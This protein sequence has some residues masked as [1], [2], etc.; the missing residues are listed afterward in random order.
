MHNPSEVK[1]WRKQVEQS[2]QLA[3]P[4]FAGLTRL[5]NFRPWL[6]REAV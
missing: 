5:D 4:A 3:R 6:I 1:T 2:V